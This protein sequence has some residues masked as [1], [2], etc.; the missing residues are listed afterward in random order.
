M[1]GG[2]LDVRNVKELCMSKKT[3]CELLMYGLGNVLPLIKIP[4]GTE[5]SGASS[6]ATALGAGKGPKKRPGK[7]LTAPPKKAAGN[8]Q[9]DSSDEEVED[10]IVL[11]AREVSLYLSTIN[12]IQTPELLNPVMWFHEHR[13]DGFPDIKIMAGALLAVQ[14]TSAASEGF[15]SEGRRLITDMRSRLQGRRAAR[16]IVSRIRHNIQKVGA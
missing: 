6:S 16:L 14:A 2:L 9:A 10:L 7:A 4:K 3:A 11:H 5:L 1:G 8:F 12:M 15:F 13:N